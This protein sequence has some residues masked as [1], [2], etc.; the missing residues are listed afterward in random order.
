M[1]QKIHPEPLQVSMPSRRHWKL[2]R[3]MQSV[4]LMA[5]SQVLFLTVAGQVV[6]AGDVNV[7][8]NDQAQMTIAY[9]EPGAIADANRLQDYINRMTGV[10]L[11]VVD[12]ST[13]PQ[14]PLI[15]VGPQAA[16]TVGINIPQSYPG[17][18]R[19]VAKQVG[20]D[21]V[22]AGND[23]QAYSGTRHAIDMFLEKLG[24]EPYGPDPDWHVV[25]HYDDLVV[26]NINIDTSPA[27]EKRSTF[28][29]QH[30][31]GGVSHPDFDGLSWGN[32]GTPFH[33][34]HNYYQM[35]PPAQFFNDHP[36]WYSLI[37]GV[38]TSTGA[39]QICFSNAEVQARAIDLA[40]AHFN[41]DSSQVMFSLSANDGAG[42]C[43]CASCSA[44]GAN[45]AAQTVS[46]SNIVVAGLRTTHP[47][48][49]VAFI[50]YAGTSAAPPLTAEK[51]DPGVQ[52]F[53]INNTC[54]VHS[55][56]DPSCQWD[57]VIPKGPWKTNLA[58]WQMS[59]ADVSGIYEY[60]LP[61]WGGW[62]NVPYVP[63]DA[64]LRDLQFYR[65]QGIRYMYYEGYSV[66]VIEDA[67][68]RWPLAYVVSK[69]MWNPDLTAEQ[70]LRPACQKLFGNASEPML[71]FYLECAKALDDS[72]VHGPGWWGLVSPELVYTAP[73]VA[74]IRG[75]LHDAW[76]LAA[77]ESS[78]VRG[79]FTDVIDAWRRAEAVVDPAGT[80]CAPWADPGG[81]YVIDEGEAL[82]LDASWSMD[83][84]DDSE[85]ASYLWDLDDNGV[86]ETD[87]GGQALCV[88]SY[89]QLTSLGLGVGGPYNISLKLTDTT[90]LFDTAYG[91]LTI[92]PEP[93][94]LALMLIGGL[95]LLRTR[96][97]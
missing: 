2:T 22:I 90:G 81:P 64:A 62:L 69:G 24:T 45:P 47:D 3:P 41:A 42:F 57:G 91:Q 36:E 25:A 9:D 15:L 40:R 83:L 53:L 19:V 72:T 56:D 20:N 28:F 97:R 16:Q 78:E 39:W 27:F 95:L 65:D 59:D 84:N 74:T 37:G 85:I 63:G 44:M 1:L 82:T 52:V 66:E 88:L 79:R 92:T 6:R 87:A 7:V 86:Y 8:I 67:P 43:E 70:I 94:T 14:G 48:K 73:V 71:D 12:L 35:Y 33:I 29:F 31:Y 60:Y 55:L 5:F 4:L 51:A 54:G 34:T 38:R 26:S 30:P 77:A 93:A 49:D 58:K 18:E 75:Q 76:A 21:L 10:T 89:A 68:I 11:S 46:F 23:A 61:S 80:P 32:G 13:S 17:G 96:R 50:A